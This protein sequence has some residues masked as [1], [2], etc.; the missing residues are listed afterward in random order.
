MTDEFISVDRKTVLQIHVYLRLLNVDN[1]DGI[2][3]VA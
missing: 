1:R 3:Q 2:Y